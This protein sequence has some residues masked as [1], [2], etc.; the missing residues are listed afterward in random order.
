M[1]TASHNPKQDNGLKIIERNGSMLDPNWEKFVEEM[2]NT[3]D[4]FSFLKDFNENK[5]E[6]FKPELDIFE[7]KA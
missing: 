2:V 1:I 6:T 5:N 4:I 3:D 7:N